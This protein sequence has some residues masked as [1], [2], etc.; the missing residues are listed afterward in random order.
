MKVTT[1]TAVTFIVEM[2]RDEAQALYR[3][4]GTVGG[5]PSG[6]RGHIDSLCYGL[7]AAD[8]S[9]DEHDMTDGLL[10]GNLYF[11]D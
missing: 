6:S 8:P 9:L 5:N 7:Y 4:L 11:K 10:D 2:N 3:V 1:T